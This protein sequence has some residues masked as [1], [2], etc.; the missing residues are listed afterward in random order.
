MMA[1]Y[2]FLSYTEPCPH[3][4]PSQHVGVRI[5]NPVPGIL[6]KYG[7][8]NIAHYWCDR[9]YH[10]VGGNRQVCQLQGGVLKWSGSQPSCKGKA[11]LHDDDK[12][13]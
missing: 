1:A 3:P 2:Y 9:G 11:F 12:T 7:K 5:E 8:D 13:E 10:L 6:P 4:F